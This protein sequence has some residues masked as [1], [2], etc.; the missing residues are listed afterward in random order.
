MNTVY[1][2]QNNKK[3]KRKQKISLK[4]K[5]KVVLKKITHR[6]TLQ[7]LYIEIL[8]QPMERWDYYPFLAIV[9]TVT[10]GFHLT[11]WRSWRD[12]PLMFHPYQQPL[13]LIWYKF[14]D[15]NLAKDTVVTLIKTLQKIEIS[16]AVVPNNYTII[17]NTLQQLTKHKS[18]Y[19][20]GKCALKDSEKCA[21]A[22]IRK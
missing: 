8:I 18:I 2:K 10:R 1:R 12:L 14:I 4:P 13:N 9:L 6:V 5:S 21:E 3:Q 17:P 7:L 22:G 20:Q 19:V 15:P 11:L 16:F